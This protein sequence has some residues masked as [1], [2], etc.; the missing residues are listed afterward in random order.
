M[1]MERRAPASK[2]SGLQ[3]CPSQAYVQHALAVNLAFAL[4][5][6]VSHS[7]TVKLFEQYLQ[8]TLCSAPS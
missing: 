7:V 6:V 5:H 2:G 3:W 8:N 1:F 4:K